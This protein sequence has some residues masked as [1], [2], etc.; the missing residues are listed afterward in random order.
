MRIDG[1][2]NFYP[3]EVIKMVR[4]RK[5][6]VKKNLIVE[7][8]EMKPIKKLTLDFSKLDDLSLSKLRE[9]VD[10]VEDVRFAPEKDVIIC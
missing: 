1:K 6:A 4:A 10:E 2:V 5:A 9:L 8:V 3:D 7:G